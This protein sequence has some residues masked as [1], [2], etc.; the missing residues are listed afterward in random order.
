MA[1]RIKFIENL[2]YLKDSIATPTIITLDQVRKV[3]FQPDFSLYLDLELS[4]IFIKDKVVKST[5]LPTLGVT[6]LLR[7]DMENDLQQFDTMLDIIV[8]IF[9]QNIHNFIF[10]LDNVDHE[11]VLV[12]PMFDKQMEPCQVDNNESALKS[13]LC[14]A[15]FPV[16][17]GDNYDVLDF[18][19]TTSD[20]NYKLNLT[21][22]EDITK[23]FYPVIH[24]TSK[25]AWISD[26]DTWEQ[27]ASIYDRE[28]DLYITL[29]RNYGK[30]G[31]K[32]VSD[33]LSHIDY[34][35][36]KMNIN[37]DY[38]KEYTD[39]ISS[40][41]PKAGIEFMMEATFDNHKLVTI[42]DKIS[43]VKDDLK[44]GVLRALYKCLGYMVAQKIHCCKE[45]RHL[46]EETL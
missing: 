22:I 9:K 16:S 28:R 45:C 7:K 27:R 2:S 14:T 12:K 39:M 1:T 4:Q 6:G 21:R 37:D 33:I 41:L 10:Y 23:A 24:N 38:D 25:I 13:T 11:A 40:K 46:D 36:S 32:Q 20:K 15:H 18:C 30:G 29:P 44:P 17:P 5:I 19:Q 34:L 26:K 3:D 31:Y 43:S 35:I 42:M 8:P